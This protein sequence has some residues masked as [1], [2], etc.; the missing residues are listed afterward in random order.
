MQSRDTYSSFDL[1]QYILLYSALNTVI[2]LAMHTFAIV[3]IASYVARD[4]VIFSNNRFVKGIR[5]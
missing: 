1:Y 2:I 5:G 4:H 3:Y